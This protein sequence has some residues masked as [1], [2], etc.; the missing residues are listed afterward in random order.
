MSW[1]T[2][3]KE[4]ALSIAAADD[5]I[6]RVVAGPGTGK[7]YTL[8]RKVQRLLESGV[9]PKEIFVSTFTRTAAADLQSD[10]L[11]LGVSGADEIEARTLHSFAYGLLLRDDVLTA[12]QRTPRPLL[13]FEER[14]LIKDMIYACIDL[15][16][17]KIK[18]VKGILSEFSSAWA[19]LQHE[20]PGWAPDDTRKSFE[21]KLKKWLSYHQCM[22]VGEII[23]ETLKY[24]RSNPLSE[25]RSRYNYV[26]V[27]EYQ[28]L[29]KAEQVLID[30]ISPDKLTIIG[31]EDQSIYSFK[32]AHPEG[33]TEFGN[34][35]QNLFDG[36]LLECRR[37]PHA[38][39]DAANSLISNNASRSSRSL[40]KFEGREDCEF[41]ICQWDSDK[42]ESEGVSKF[43][44]DGINSGSF[45]AGDV[46]IL[47]PR[48]PF[49]Q[50]I[51]S[52]L[53]K[54]GIEA[55]SFFADELC[56]GKPEKDE[57]SK[58]QQSLT[59]LSLLADPEDRVSLRVWI[60]YGADSLRSSGWAKI[61][62]KSN[63][64]GVSPRA[65]LKGLNDGTFKL[66]HTKDIT[67]RYS[68]LLK[69][70][71]ELSDKSGD[72]L[73]KAI[74]DIDSESRESIRA[75]LPSVMD[76][77]YNPM[78]M[79]KEVRQAISSPELPQKA[80]YVRLMS[81]HKSKGLTAKV[82]IVLGCAEGIIPFVK[83]GLTDY[84]RNRAIEE[85]RRLFYV[86]IT[87]TTRTLILSSFQSIN[88][89][90]A[91]R[92]NIS[93]PRSRGQSLLFNP[94]Q[95]LADLGPSAPSAISGQDFLNITHGPK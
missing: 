92:M 1:D 79:N 23:P 52:K 32:H 42:A 16:L 57:E 13:S 37:C 66:A 28:D 89:M 87:R 2:D 72:D 56:S 83:K 48:R 43:L 8:K 5:K 94:S 73:F 40:Q 65:I 77:S 29:N 41:T 54:A 24:L 39:V 62:E 35:H 14:F 51:K 4:P 71:S 64:D 75:I 19:T 50:S 81:L 59:L 30:L 58:L 17:S 67:A 20:E 44:I 22:L 90:Q 9:S 55:H 45:N 21:L 27:D 69:H 85:A 12:T 31:D 82:V 26:F 25:F 46:L 68:K 10:L 38:V 15:G 60:G 84:Q 74:F 80:E 3:L 33:I 61:I 91:M 76:D 6:S 63:S 7:S 78:K 47:S 18:D 70:E 86:A 11:D 49:A 36:S 95:F 53:I 93:S 34:N 88:R